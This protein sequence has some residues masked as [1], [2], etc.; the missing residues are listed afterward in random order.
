[1]SL[2]NAEIAKIAINT[3]VTTKITFA[4]MLAGL[5]EKIPGGDVDVVTQALGSDSR[6]GQKYL[7]GA[8]GYGGPCFPR[9]NLALAFIARAVGASAGIAETTDRMN[10]E[11][12][13]RV[14]ATLRPL[15][16]ARSTVGVLGLAYKPSSHVVDES[17]GVY[18]AQAIAAAGARV[19]AYDP[20]AGRAGAAALNGAVTIKTSA[21]ELIDSADIVVIATADPEFTTLT[22]GDFLASHDS[23]IVL[24]C[25]RILRS[26]LE[27]QRQITYL[28]I[29]RSKDDES[30][31][32]VLR[33]LW[34][35]TA[36]T[37]AT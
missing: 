22:A 14:T 12:A 13:A 24:D 11:Q 33:N 3:F 30:N 27:N 1:M 7:K 35:E 37:A 18:L 28:A 4:N 19:I 10:R 8:V 15:I 6:I 5:C 9:D 20:L 32:E 21:R 31:A 34:A 17:P 36:E 23:I 16:G 25:W 29:G 26:Q 2:E